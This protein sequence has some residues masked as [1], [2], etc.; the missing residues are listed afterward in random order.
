MNVFKVGEVYKTLCKELFIEDQKQQAERINPVEVE[1]LI[2]KFARRLEFGEFHNQVATDAVR[3]LAR[4]DRDWMV[5]GRTPAGLCAACI[6]LAARMN[7]FRRSVREVVYVV[8]VADVTIAKRLEEFRR[9]KAGSLSV[10]QFRKYS[11]RLKDEALPP[12]VYN[13]QDKHKKRVKYNQPTSEE[14][15]N[16]EVNRDSTSQPPVA[17]PPQKRPRVDQD[18][19]VVPDLPASRIEPPID[20]TLLQAVEVARSELGEDPADAVDTEVLSDTESVASTASTPGRKRR[21]K[22]EKAPPPEITEA[23]LIVEEELQH[24]IESTIASDE[25]QR[26]LREEFVNASEARAKAL[27]EQMRGSNAALNEEEIGLT[28]FDDDPEVANCMLS[29][30]EVAIKERIWVTHNEDWMRQ[31]QQRLLEKEM[32]EAKGKKKAKPRGKRGRLGDGS[33]LEGTEV[34]S[35]SDAVEAMINKR[36]APSWSKHIDY[37]RLRNIYSRGDGESAAGD[38]GTKET[39]EDQ[40][41]TEGQKPE[42]GTSQPPAPQLVEPPV[43]GVAAAVSAGTTVLPTPPTTQ[44]PEGPIHIESDAESDESEDDEE[45][46]APEELMQEDQYEDDEDGIE[47]GD[48]AED[49]YGPQYD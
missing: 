19:F 25:T 10:D 46:H 24:Q 33:V 8:R 4:M 16:E 37:E 7:N 34:H 38:G 30:A 15:H 5:T 27:A 44:L 20:P 6:I 43:H 13:S 26:I 40:P 47:H 23:D 9:T 32:A 18:G 36:A 1:P 14:D 35:P 3:I 29:P 41:S 39:T 21:K 22:K 12:S 45:E 48:E 28:E 11:H 31:Q 42:V 49:D 2:D 17:V